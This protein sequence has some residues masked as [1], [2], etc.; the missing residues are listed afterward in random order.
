[1]TGLHTDKNVTDILQSQGILILKAL[2]K[3]FELG[4][5]QYPRLLSDL[6]CLTRFSS[7]P[8]SIT[9]GIQVRDMLN[10]KL[11]CTLFVQDQD[12]GIRCGMGAK[13]LLN[14]KMHDF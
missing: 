1:M 4:W 12:A 2:E 13:Y 10:R 7:A 8:L 6:T 3:T 9:P 5:D 14:T 11:R